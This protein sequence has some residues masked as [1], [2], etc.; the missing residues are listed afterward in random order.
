MVIEMNRA[1]LKILAV[2][3]LAGFLWLHYFA[4]EI[5]NLNGYVIIGSD[6]LISFGVV[7]TYYE[8]KKEL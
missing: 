7:K 4:Y 5:F 8:I 6:V 2:A 3:F 1:I